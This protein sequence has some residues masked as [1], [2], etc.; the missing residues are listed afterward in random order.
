MSADI[1]KSP[2]VFVKAVIFPDLSESA[3]ECPAMVIS[4]PAED[5]PSVFEAVSVSVCVPED[6]EPAVPLMTYESPETLPEIPSGSLPS[7]VHT[8]F[9]P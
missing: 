3:P 1:R 5:S 9:V 6:P 8:I 7:R 2:T 4:M